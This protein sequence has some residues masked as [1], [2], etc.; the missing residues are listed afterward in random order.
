MASVDVAGT[1]KDNNVPIP[2]KKNVLNE[3]LVHKRRKRKNTKRQQVSELAKRKY[4]ENGNPSPFWT[5]RSV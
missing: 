4:D 3:E 2:S 5:C 1:N